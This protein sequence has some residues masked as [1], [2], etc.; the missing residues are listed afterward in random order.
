MGIDIL[1]GADFYWDFVSNE[2]RR[3]EQPGPVALLTRLGWVLSGPIDNYCEEVRSTTNF[4][5]THVLRVD[6]T[7]VQDVQNTNITE[8]LKIF[9]DLESIGIR[10]DESSV[11][12]KYYIG[13]MCLQ[14]V[15][16][17]HKSKFLPG[18]VEKNSSTIRSSGRNRTYARLCDAG[19][20][21]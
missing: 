11:Y 6:A 17:I 14:R 12:D 5:A 7:T 19:P 9:W 4:A 16:I 2:S 1:I 8:Q 18:T 20:L 3:V 10:G 15:D 21:L 13:L